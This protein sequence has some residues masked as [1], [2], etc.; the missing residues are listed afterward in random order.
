MKHLL[1]ENTRITGTNGSNV[2]DNQDD[3]P[4]RTASIIK[5]GCDERK[6]EALQ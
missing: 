4:L 5:E 3:F 2:S 1:N 6:I